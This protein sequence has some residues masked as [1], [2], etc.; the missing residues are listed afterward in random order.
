[1][2]SRRRQP[3]ASAASSATRAAARSPALPVKEL[4]QP[5]LTTRPRARPP[6]RWI[7]RLHQSTGAE[8]TSC[9]VKTPAQVVPSAK[10]I[11]RTSFRSCL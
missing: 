5:A 7:C 8:P 3:M 6:E 2:T 11:S 1:M 4:A 9:R 10:R